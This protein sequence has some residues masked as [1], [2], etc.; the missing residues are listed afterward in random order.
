MAVGES[1]LITGGSSGIGWAAAELLARK[2]YR[3]FATTRSL[4]RRR[5]VVEET[6][7]KY[8][9]KITFIEMDAT[10]DES[11]ERCV[12]KVIGAC[13]RIDNLVCNAGIAII[14]SIEETPMSLVRA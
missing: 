1:V 7:R 2:G 11:V 8:A 3:V 14:G 12:A 10:S 13:Q 5:D 9:G 6:A 4:G